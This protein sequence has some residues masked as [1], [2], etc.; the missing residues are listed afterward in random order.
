METSK[1]IYGTYA[2][3]YDGNIYAAF[4]QDLIFSFLQI[5]TDTKFYEGKYPFFD[6]KNLLVNEASD[7]REVWFNGKKISFFLQDYS[8]LRFQAVLAKNTKEKISVIASETSRLLIHFDELDALIQALDE[9][10]DIL[11]EEI[12]WYA[13]N[14]PAWESIVLEAYDKLK[15]KYERA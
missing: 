11:K 4:E 1:Q 6:D 2:I 12:E 9:R 5:N 3:E 15:I 10:Q 8:A 7:K 13:K 14:G